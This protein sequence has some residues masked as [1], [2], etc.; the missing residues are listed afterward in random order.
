MIDVDYF[1]TYNDTWGHLQGDRVLTAVAQLLQQ[2]SRA[3]DIVA[4]YGGEEF[5]LILPETE[6][7]EA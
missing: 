3:S 4:R 7:A 1:K 6:A 2:T 5:V